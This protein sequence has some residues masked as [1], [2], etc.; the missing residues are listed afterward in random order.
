MSIYQC[1]CP[2]PDAVLA[3]ALACAGLTAQ[4]PSPAPRTEPLSPALAAA[5]PF[6]DVDPDG[7]VWA[8]GAGWKAAFAAD[9]FQFIPFLGSDAPRNFPLGLRLVGVVAGTRSLPLART[10]PALSNG[11]R[12]TIARGACTEFYDLARDHVEQSFVF[13]AAPVAGALVVQMQV[14]TEL[15]PQPTGDGGFTFANERG[16]VRYGRATALDA[17]R[18]HIAVASRLDGDVLTLTVPATFLAQATFPLVIDPLV[19]TFAVAPG[20]GAPSQINADCAHVGTYTGLTAIVHEEIYSATDHDVFVTGYESN[21][22]VGASAYVDYTTSSWTSPQIASHRGAS[23]FLVVATRNTLI[24]SIWGRTLTYAHAAA[25]TLTPSAQ[26]P[27]GSG[28]GSD[29]DVGGDPNPSPPLPGNYCVT[30]QGNFGAV[31]FNLVQTNAS[32]SSTSG[33]VLNPA[34]THATNAALS[35]SCGVGA[36]GTRQW[37]VA[38]QL[39]YSAIDED[40]YASRIALDGTVLAPGFPIDASPQVETNPEVSSLTDLIAGAERF[41]VVYERAVPPIGPLPAR[42]QIFGRVCTDSTPLSGDVNL[43]QL[44][45]TD[46]LGDQLDPCVDTDG[47]RFVVGFTEDPAI[48]SQDL[49]PYLATVHVI[50]DTFGYTELPVALS[51]YPGRDEN[52]RVASERSGGTFTPRYVATFQTEVL[53]TGASSV[54]G[55][56]YMGHLAAGPTSYF[57]HQ[58]PG[59]GPLTMDA[60]GLPALANTFYLDL[61]NVQ[62]IPVIAFGDWI[63]PTPLCANCQLGVDPASMQ[64]FVT[65]HLAITVPQEAALIGAQFGT[66]GI[67]LLAPNGCTSPLAFTL[68][69][70]IMVTLL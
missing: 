11:D 9:G 39:R 1:R 59:C 63:A 15:T 64:L 35:K 38:W 68:S 17:Q 26:F 2:A 33:T 19:S 50:N 20:I 6:V 22:A 65:T 32:V 66:Q 58:I 16:G 62:S 40:I 49:V 55:A 53:A 43:S 23:Q 14:I 30:W 54:S 37:I 10:Q 42:Q 69:D 47:T 44:L 48:L 29:P 28:P 3:F 45:S 5:K 12:V 46:P 61:T 25:T 56:Y 7:T 51:S 60:S 34:G 52:L 31:L 13:A 8:R 70:M 21:G 24:P 18:R 27:I 41:A 67:D 36:Y 57:S 4:T